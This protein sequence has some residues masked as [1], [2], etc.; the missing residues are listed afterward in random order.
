M[1]IETFPIP[2]PPAADASKF[3]D[4]GREVRGV[5]PGR[6]TDKEFKEI[7]RLLYEVCL[8]TLMTSV[9]PYLS[10]CRAA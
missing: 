6:L 7:E 1:A 5:H 4:F 10:V 2:L 8:T 9:L 3:K